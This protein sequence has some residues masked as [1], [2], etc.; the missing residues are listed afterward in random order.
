M[1]TNDITLRQEVARSEKKRTPWVQTDRGSHEAWAKMVVESPRAAALLH[2][3][4]SRMDSLNAVVISQDLLAKIMGVHVRTIA[5]AIKDLTT[6]GWVEVIRLGKGRECAYV[7]NSRVAWSQKR[8]NL[9]Y[10]IFHAVVVADHDDQ[11]PDLLEQ[12]ALRPLPPLYQGERQIPTGAGEPPPSQ[13]AFD[14]FEHDLPTRGGD[15]Q[16]ERDRLEQQG[17]HRLFGDKKGDL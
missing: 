7:V 3:L 16:A 15:D 10:S 9:K 6:G 13:P 17:Q 1:D 2:H 4:I 14:G 5:R 11:E 8:E 12:G